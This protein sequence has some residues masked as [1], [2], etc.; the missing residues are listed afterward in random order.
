MYFFLIF[1]KPSIYHSIKYD[2]SYYKVTGYLYF[3]EFYFKL[4]VDHFFLFRMAV[5]FVSSILKLFHSQCGS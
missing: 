4:E 5:L 3:V 2:I 1:R